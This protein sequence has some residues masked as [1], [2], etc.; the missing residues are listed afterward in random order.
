MLGSSPPNCCHVIACLTA[1]YS[2]GARIRKKLLPAQ[3]SIFFFVQGFVCKFLSVSA[4]THTLTHSVTHSQTYFWLSAHYKDKTFQNISTILLM[5]SHHT[6][7]LSTVLNHNY[8]LMNKLASQPSV[9]TVFFLRLN[10]FV[11]TMALIEIF[12]KCKYEGK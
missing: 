9:C 6:L 3:K 2:L 11:I 10:L 1:Q 4:Y 5:F 7:N 8:Y 12:P